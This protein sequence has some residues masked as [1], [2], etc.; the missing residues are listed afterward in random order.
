VKALLEQLRSS[1][2][3]QDVV[4]ATRHPSEEQPASSSERVDGPPASANVA[5]LL[6]Q[7]HTHAPD[8]V[9][10]GHSMMATMD[11]RYQDLKAMSFQQ[12][13]PHLADLSSKPEF[14]DQIR[15]VSKVGHQEMEVD[16]SFADEVAAR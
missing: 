11:T 7:L 15:E 14:V 8:R 6:S 5:S 12:A 10:D 3:W 16:T 13:L 1:Q 4:S 2:A 9:D